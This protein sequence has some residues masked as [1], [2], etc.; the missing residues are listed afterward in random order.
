[1]PA[2][3]GTVGLR[4]SACEGKQERKER[5]AGLRLG[6]SGRAKAPSGGR[7]RVFTGDQ[8]NPL[9]CIP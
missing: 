4:G 5:D 3:L 8:E 9:K 6:A 2:A 7:P 1:M